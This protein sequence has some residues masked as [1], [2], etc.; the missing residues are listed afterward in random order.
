MYIHAR[1]QFVSHFDFP[2][3]SGQIYAVDHRRGNDFDEGMILTRQT[4][5]NW[6]YTGFEQKITLDR[7]I[8]PASSQ[9]RL[10]GRASLLLR[11]HLC[12]FLM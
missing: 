12:A 11:L 5:I 10:G 8:I 9:R 1:L 2:L 6:E 3:F 7:M 4:V